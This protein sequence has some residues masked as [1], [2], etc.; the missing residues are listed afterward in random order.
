M[1][2]KYTIPL[3]P[4]TKKNSQRILVNRKTGMPFI[5]P[6]SAYK[7]YEAQAI[8]FLTPKPKTPLA[9]RYRVAAE[10]YMPT[11][12]RV[13]LTNL[14]EAAHD[15]LVAAK[16]LADDNNTIIASVDGSRVLYDK[17]NP[18]TEIIIQELNEPKKTKKNISRRCGCYG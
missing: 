1:I 12:R 10:F 14:L 6:S 2:Y 11:R 18:R 13:D 4:V 15:T 7:R 17:E 8:Y 3:P 16:I 9:G 5:A